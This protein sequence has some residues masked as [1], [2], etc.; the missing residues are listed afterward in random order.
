MNNKI[1][2]IGKL[3]SVDATLPDGEYQGVWGGFTIHVTTPADRQGY[4]LKTNSGVKG[5]GIPVVVNIVNGEA[6]FEENKQNKR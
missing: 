1:I 4:E 5:F 6:T 2:K 3:V